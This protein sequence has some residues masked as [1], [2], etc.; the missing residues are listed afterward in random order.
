MTYFHQY[1]TNI[2]C[3]STLLLTTDVKLSSNGAVNVVQC[4]I[5]ST[6]LSLTKKRQAKKN[7]C[8]RPDQATCSDSTRHKALAGAQGDTGTV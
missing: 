7:V 6:A 8:T 3:T 2:T 5:N 1:F 4:Y